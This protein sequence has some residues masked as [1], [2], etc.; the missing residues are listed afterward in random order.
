LDKIGVSIITFPLLSFSKALQKIEDLGFK[1]VE[2]WTEFPEVWKLDLSGRIKIFKEV[3]PS[4][5]FDLS[6]HTPITDLN[7]SSYHPKIQEIS[8]K[9][10]EE[11]LILANKT[12]IKKAVVHGGFKPKE[13]PFNKLKK[14]NLHLYLNQT[15]K[16]IKQILKQGEE[17]GVEILVENAEYDE[18]HKILRTYDDFQ[19]ITK[20]INKEFS[21]VYDISHSLPAGIKKSKEFITKI[22][23]RIKEVH[24]SFFDKKTKKH[25]LPLTSQSKEALEILN[26]IK[27]HHLPSSPNLI[28]EI[29]NLPLNVSLRSNTLKRSL[30]LIKTLSL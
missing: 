13:K 16:G 11:T 30:N 27:K 26:H 25:H 10:I 22:K 23:H 19:T 21:I 24:L 18:Q 17:L 7:I 9:E 29:Y 15:S 5:N 2:L 4:F 20:K 28:F 3:L 1:A 12:G 14:P 8:L 6:I